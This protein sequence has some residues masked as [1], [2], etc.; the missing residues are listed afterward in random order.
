MEVLGVYELEPYIEK[1]AFEACTTIKRVYMPDSILSMSSYCFAD[2]VNLE[3]VR[4][5]PNLYRIW[6]GVFRDC[7]SLKK[8][9]IPEGIQSILPYAFLR[10]YQLEEVNLPQSLERIYSHA[11]KDCENLQ[12]VDIPKGVEIIDGSAFAGTAWKQTWGKNT[13]IE[14]ENCLLQ[15]SREEEI[16]EIPE[17]VEYIG[18]GALYDCKQMKVLILPESV[19][20]CGIFMVED[21]ETF[22]YLV[23]KN[24]EMK[25][26]NG[27]P[28]S[29]G[30]QDIT[31]VGIKGSTAE[32]YAEE[33]EYAFSESL[34]EE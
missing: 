19:K 20:E 8:I 21:Q 17:G 24:P 5:S 14:G 10:C 16:I 15:Y 9:D 34:P 6:I 22:R 28:I 11:F 2:C 26:P 23:V 33:M 1:G 27:D 25:F 12:S 30:H 29:K 4:L 13:V 32:A 31:I 3:E 7:E 18:D